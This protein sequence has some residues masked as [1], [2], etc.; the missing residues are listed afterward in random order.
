MCV[1]EFVPQSYHSLLV[2]GCLELP[3]SLAIYDH[4]INLL[5]M[6]SSAF[7]KLSSNRG[8]YSVEPIRI[9]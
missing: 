1:V 2:H 7:M 5:E 8:R 3:T 4:T 9:E 6:T